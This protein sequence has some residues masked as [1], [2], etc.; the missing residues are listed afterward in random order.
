MN[1]AHKAQEKSYIH[2]DENFKLQAYIHIT[3]DLFPLKVV[4]VFDSFEK[5]PLSFQNEVNKLLPRGTV[6]LV[7]GECTTFTICRVSFLGVCA[8]AMFFSDGIIACTLLGC[9]TV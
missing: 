6:K 5:K 9:E 8:N 1:Y 3:N 7:E 4:L 2:V